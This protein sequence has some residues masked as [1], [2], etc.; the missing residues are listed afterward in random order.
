MRPPWLA[1]LLL[2]AVALVGLSPARAE[3]DDG[4]PRNPRFLLMDSQGH[5][6]DETTFAGRF[7]L[8]TFGY[9][10]CP[11]VCPTTLAEIAEVLASLGERAERLQPIFITVDPA[12]DTPEVIG[13]YTA[14]FDQRIVGLTGDPALVARV[15]RNYRVRFDVVREPGSAEAE[16]SVDHTAGMFLLGPSGDY[17][18]RFAYGT[19][20]PVIV[21]RLKAYFDAARYR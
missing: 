11:D 20:V 19:P 9:T 16:Y 7:Q 13:R 2:L 12:R 10:F 1:L 18:T 8:I 4:G 14:F 17:L 15:A 6:V 3:Y 21:R 5:T